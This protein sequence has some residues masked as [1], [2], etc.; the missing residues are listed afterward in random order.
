MIMMNML[1]RIAR[2]AYIG[3]FSILRFDFR[4]AMAVS[5]MLFAGSGIS[6][7]LDRQ[8]IADSFAFCCFY[9]LIAAA[10]LMTIQYIREASLKSRRKDKGTDNNRE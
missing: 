7:A 10:V 5:L 3:I 1:A 8:D 9:F 4:I 6:F 2:V